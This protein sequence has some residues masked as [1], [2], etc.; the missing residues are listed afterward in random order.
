LISFIEGLSEAQEGAPNCLLGVT[1]KPLAQHV[2]DVADAHSVLERAH[3]GER[4]ER[5]MLWTTGVIRLCS[6]FKNDSCEGGQPE[7]LDLRWMS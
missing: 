3:R 5:E 6:T 4:P 1:G 2:V 7:A